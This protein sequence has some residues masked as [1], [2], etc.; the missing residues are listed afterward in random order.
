M[1]AVQ[2]LADQKQG[3][4]DANG[5]RPPSGHRKLKLTISLGLMLSA[6]GVKMQMDEKMTRSSGMFPL[7][8]NISLTTAYVVQAT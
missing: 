5:R 4:G 6:C 3:N 7:T 2:G 1:Y 8:W